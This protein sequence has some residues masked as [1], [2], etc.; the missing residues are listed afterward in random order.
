MMK[1][2]FKTVLKNVLR[3]CKTVSIKLCIHREDKS[4]SVQ[5]SYTDIVVAR[6][7]KFLSVVTPPSISQYSSPMHTN[8]LFLVQVNTNQ[9]ANK[10]TL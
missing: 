7:M 9:A 6:T 8:M 3:T 4:K 5:F 10:T 1:I 2:T